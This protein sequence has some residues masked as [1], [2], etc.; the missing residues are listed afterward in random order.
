MQE[1]MGSITEDTFPAFQ[2]NGAA[3]NSGQYAPECIQE[4]GIGRQDNGASV[5]ESLMSRYGFFA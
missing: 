1:A 5:Q 3:S 4:E 2:E